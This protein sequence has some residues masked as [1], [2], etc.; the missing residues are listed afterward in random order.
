MLVIEIDGRSYN[1]EEAF[2]KDEIRQHRLESFG[3]Q[4]LRFTEAE[5]KYDRL[6]VL[7]SI[8]GTIIEILKSNQNIKLPADFDRSLLT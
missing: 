4:F 5:V 7:R 6:N 1:F 3:L 2:L 8:E